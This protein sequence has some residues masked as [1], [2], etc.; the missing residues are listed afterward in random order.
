M[1][2]SPP[3]NG[4]EQPLGGDDVVPIEFLFG[5]PPDLSMADYDRTSPVE[6]L[7]PRT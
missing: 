1:R 4:G 7:L 3:C 5:Q 2:S 6:R